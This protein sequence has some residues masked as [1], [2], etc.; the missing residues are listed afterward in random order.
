MGHDITCY[1]KTAAERDE[2]YKRLVGEHG[3]YDDAWAERYGRYRDEV[4]V[5]YFRRSMGYHRSPVGALLYDALGEKAREHYAGVSGD[6]GSAVFGIE[7]LMLARARC[8]QMGEGYDA[9]WQHEWLGE[10]IEFLDKCI[11]YA[12]EHPER[13]AEITFS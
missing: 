6:G 11:A 10:E 4:E 3:A 7:E 13:R 12:S 2:A 1:R 9:A 8:M 5:A